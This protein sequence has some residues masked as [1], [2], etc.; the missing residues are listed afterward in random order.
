LL[1]QFRRRLVAQ[2]G[3]ALLQELIR[4][5]SALARRRCRLLAC[6]AWLCRHHVA[7]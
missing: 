1:R 3:D 4:H 5:L 7:P 6:S 2:P